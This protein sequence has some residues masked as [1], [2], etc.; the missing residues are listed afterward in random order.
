METINYKAFIIHCTYISYFSSPMSPHPITP[1]LLA[2]STS[3]LVALYPWWM[4]VSSSEHIMY[5]RVWGVQSEMLNMRDTSM[6][7]NQTIHYT[8]SQNCLLFSEQTTPE[9]KQHH[10]VPS[11]PV[12]RNFLVS[13]EASGKWGEVSLLNIFLI[14]AL[15]GNWKK[16]IEE[17]PNATRNVSSNVCDH[18]LFISTEIL[19]QLLW[20]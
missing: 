18:K 13:A 11:F 10:Y 6:A 20:T 9:H 16:S 17:W 19:R 3:S 15:F 8:R 2:L 14:K 5:G 1:R 4:N 7:W 12:R